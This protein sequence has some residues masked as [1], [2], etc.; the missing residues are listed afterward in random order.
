MTPFAIQ[1]TLSALAAAAALAAAPAA[2]AL[3]FVFNDTTTGGMSAAQL[4]AV[5][6]AGNY[7][8]SQF[9]DNVTVYVDM[10]FDH[11]GA[12]I[13]GQTGSAFTSK[14]YAS[15][16]SNLVADATSSRDATAVAN[17]QTGPA[18]AFYATQGDL[19]SR[20]D[21]DGSVNNTLLGLTTANAK[22]L[23]YAT[24]TN[25]ANPD[26]TMTFSSDFSFAYTRVGGTPSGQIDFITVV[27]HELGHALGF[28]SGV[29]DID[30]CAGAGMGAACGITEGADRFEN[31]WW[32]EPLDLFRYT[33]AG[34]DMRVGGSPI[35]SIDGGVTGIETFS[36][37]S[38]YG[39][40][41]QASH[42][43]TGSVN[44]MRPY[45]SYGQAYDATGADLA[46]FD[47]IGW[48]L[49]AAV[50]EPGTWALM[51]AGLAAMGGIAR[52]RRSAV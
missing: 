45:V 4:N 49:A 1:R 52:R 18:L 47:V 42:F 14:T 46:A 10:G 36:T 48:N 16:R 44:L 2:H 24:G 15:V 50:P 41:Y 31:N 39:N 51:A 17:L 34:L 37:G 40:G 25:G 7:W 13:L 27:E 33:A 35:F 38:N 30:Y 26:A 3:T 20:F 19:S 12:S 5:T 21:N 8:S 32:Y 22:A 29:D 11:L 9:T 28:T 43:G 23:G 6:I